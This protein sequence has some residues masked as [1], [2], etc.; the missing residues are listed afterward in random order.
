LGD[1]KSGTQ[2]KTLALEIWTQIVT[3]VIQ[4]SNFP[5]VDFLSDL[6]PSPSS[7]STPPTRVANDGNLEVFRTYLAGHSVQFNKGTNGD[8]SHKNLPQSEE[9]MHWVRNAA[10]QLHRVV[11]L[12][13]PSSF[14]SNT[15]GFTGLT[16]IPP[17][18]PFRKQLVNSAH[19]LLKLCARTLASCAPVLLETLILH[20]DDDDVE[21]A[22]L[23]TNALSDVFA[24]GYAA[25]GKIDSGKEEFWETLLEDN[26]HRIMKTLPRIITVASGDVGKVVPLKLVAGIFFF[27]YSYFSYQSRISIG[28]MRLLGPLVGRIVQATLEQF[29]VPLL[30]ALEMDIFDVKISH[31]NAISANGISSLVKLYVLLT[32]CIV[33]LLESSES[34]T[35]TPN[36]TPATSGYPKKTFSHFRDEKVAEIL[37]QVCRLL[38]YYG[39]TLL[40]CDHFISS[41]L[42][43][44]NI[45]RKQVFI[46]NM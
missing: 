15:Q 21:T 46:I 26:L 42:N 17:K 5:L 4:D 34:Q 33:L 43:E 39:D 40:L 41:F 2:I 36:Q 28:Y 20:L 19:Q 18:T 35:T 25:F 23:A 13:F 16:Y 10:G 30:Q 14:A 38:G 6:S 32:K 37:T 11:T 1:W 22:Q 8:E 45:L 9:E 44:N 12:I 29:S 7:T 31:R 24:S 3:Y 27:S